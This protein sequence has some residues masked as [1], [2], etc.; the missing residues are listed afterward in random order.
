MLLHDN[1][2]AHNAIR[3]CQLLAQKMVGVLDLPPYFSDLAPANFFLFR[4]EVAI[5]G[6]CSVDVNAI[7]DL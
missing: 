5:K 4:L 3:V 1:A 2:P 6:A 7:K